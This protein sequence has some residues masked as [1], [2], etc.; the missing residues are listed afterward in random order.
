MA[1]IVLCTLNARYIHSALGLRYL[2][3][4]L[5]PLQSR[6]DI[7][8]FTL[9][10]RAVDMAERLLAHGPLILGFGV[11]IW[12]TEQTARLVAIIKQVRPQIIIVLGGPEV[13]F[14][15]DRPDW[16]GLADYVI[17][18]QA[19]TAFRDF[20]AQCLGGSRPDTRDWTATAPDPRQLVLPYA[21]YNDDDIA[22]RIIYVEASRGCPFKCEFCLSA[23]DK[24]ARPFDLAPFL[25]ALD[26]LYQRGARHFKFVDRTFN[27]KADNCAAILEFFLQRLEQ[28]LFLHFEL[29]PDHLPQRLKSLI[30][31]FPA[32]SMQFEIGIQTFN[33]KVQALISRRQDND[34]AVANVHWLRQNTRVHLHTD[35]IAGL[36][37]EDMQ[38]F[39]R[40]F[41]RL[42]ALA[43]HEI[44]LGILKRLRGAPINRH[45][46][47]YQMCYDTHPPFSILSHA[48][49]PFADRQ[50]LSRFARYWDLLANAGR[51]HVTLPLIL[52]DSPFQRFMQ[53]S[54]WLY[55]TTG[56]THRIAL[57]RL[58]DL[59]WQGLCEVLSVSVPVAEQALARDFENTGLKSVPQCLRGRITRQRQARSPIKASL[60]Q[61]RHLTKRSK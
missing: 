33:S 12:N 23:L 54:D 49:L 60:R 3:A 40:G 31:Q 32:G 50:R 59:V 29:I 7:V 42:V 16:V 43:P 35:L 39:A 15:A 18:G 57:L 30:E 25:D 19:D 20:C 41:D 14:Q 56:Q 34:K 9:E 47:V 52:A 10:Q 46:Q 22:N 13:S 44:Q 45:S 6:C 21:L 51:F 11:Y 26:E 55:Q 53:L 61:S 58:F 1:D 27:L 24:T 38:S 28:P 36:P 2:K 8:E 37:G 4:N 17:S 48:S 5:G